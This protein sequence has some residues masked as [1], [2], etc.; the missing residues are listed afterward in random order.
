MTWLEDV[1][2][3]LLL[4]D[5]PETQDP[6]ARIAGGNGELSR[7]FVPTPKDRGP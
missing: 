2:A 4:Y 3:T 1:D 6:R 7:Q 5:G